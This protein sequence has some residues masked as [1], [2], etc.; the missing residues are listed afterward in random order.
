MFVEVTV[1]MNCINLFVFTLSHLKII[2]QLHY[3]LLLQVI[4]SSH[5]HYKIC[6][7]GHTSSNNCLYYGHG[8]IRDPQEFNWAFVMFLK[9]MVIPIPMMLLQVCSE[10]PTTTLRLPQSTCTAWQYC[11]LPGLYRFHHVSGFWC[12]LRPGEYLTSVWRLG[13]C[14]CLSMPTEDLHLGSCHWVSAG[15]LCLSCC[16]SPCKFQFFFTSFWLWWQEHW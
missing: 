2:L 14:C 15:V 3:I 16:W 12:C 1:H 4:L 5:V 7:V 8:R 13:N 9:P 10:F 11:V 6:L